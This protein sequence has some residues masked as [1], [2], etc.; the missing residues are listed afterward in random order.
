MPIDANIVNRPRNHL[1]DRQ[2]SPLSRALSSGL[3]QLK[4]AVGI[5]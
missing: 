1:P 2:A 4:Q 3:N 5:G